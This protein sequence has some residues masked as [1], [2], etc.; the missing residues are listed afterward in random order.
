VSKP[1]KNREP[2]PSKKKVYFKV[3]TN[4]TSKTAAYNNMPS[5]VKTKLADMLITIGEEEQAIERLRYQLASHPDFEPYAAF[6]RLDRRNK[7]MLTSEQVRDFLRDNRHSSILE[8]QCTLVVKYFSSEL[9]DKR[10]DRPNRMS[11]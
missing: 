11:F 3:G 9:P 5:I 10:G 1:F 8:S 6:S 2:S 4:P 7:G